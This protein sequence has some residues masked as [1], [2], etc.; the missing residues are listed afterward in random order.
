MLREKTNWKDGVRAVYVI[1][2]YDLFFQGPSVVADRAIGVLC[3]WHG[4]STDLR[5]TVE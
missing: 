5:S 2:K 1:L 4:K 3:Y